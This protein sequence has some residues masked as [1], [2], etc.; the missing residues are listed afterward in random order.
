[1][2]QTFAAKLTEKKIITHDVFIYKFELLEPKEIAFQAGQYVI[3]FV[4]QA[5]GTAVRRL[6]SMFSPPSQKNQIEMLIQHVP[7]GIASLYLES[8]KIG[9]EVKLQGPAG[10]FLLK[11][12]S[13]DSVFLATGTGIAPMWSIFHSASE[14]FHNTKNT[15]LL[16]FP[17]FKDMYFIPE[18]K[19]LHNTYPDFNFFI[20]VSREQD[21]K[22][23]DPVHQE[24]IVLGRITH[25]F[26]E[27]L[28]QDP[29]LISRNF[30]ICAGKEIVDSLRQ[31]LTDK[32]IAKENIHFEKYV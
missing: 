15:V 2:I 23:L 1:M 30:Y 25:K 26:D 31:Y 17:T 18:L 27:L 32:G 21:K 24:H 5:D 8:L 20:C 13:K 10:L 28:S 11:Q 6:Y 9:D 16:G 19:Q 29:T 4:P 14:H 12:P 22:D 7:N 3:L